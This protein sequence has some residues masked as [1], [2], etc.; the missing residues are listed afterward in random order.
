ML[1][2]SLITLL[3]VLSFLG[4]Q[5]CSTRSGKT[6]HTE[7]LNQLDKA[8]EEVKSVDSYYKVECALPPV[9]EGDSVVEL[10]AA[11]QKTMEQDAECFNRHNALIP[12]LK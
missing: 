9:M 11:L 4:L 6:T 12:Q 10:L 3:V 1:T 8:T 2:R 5:S 7:A